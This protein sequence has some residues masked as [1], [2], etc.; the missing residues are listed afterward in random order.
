M[1]DIVAQMH[2]VKYVRGALDHLVSLYLAASGLKPVS[3]SNETWRSV[4]AQVRADLQARGMLL[5]QIESA[6][7]AQIGWGNERIFGQSI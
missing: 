6:C 3:L 5:S 1:L 7:P 4:Y 2:E